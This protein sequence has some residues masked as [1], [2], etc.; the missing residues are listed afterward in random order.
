MLRTHRFGEVT[1]TA[2]QAC[3]GLFHQGGLNGKQTILCNDFQKFLVHHRILLFETAK[4]PALSVPYF[5]LQ[6]ID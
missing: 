3:G 1:L 6:L 2:H 4:R 5:L